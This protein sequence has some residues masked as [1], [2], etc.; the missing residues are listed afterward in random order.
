MPDYVQRLVARND[1]FTEVITPMTT[2]QV[3]LK[4]LP[5]TLQGETP[6]AV[7]HSGGTDDVDDKTLKTGPGGVQET[8]FELRV[9]LLALYADQPAVEG[10]PVTYYEEEAAN[11]LDMLS[12]ELL[13]LVRTKRKVKTKWQ[14]LEWFGMSIASDLLKIDGTLYL[15][16]IVLLRMTLF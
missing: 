15:H 2:P 11:Q 3:K 4:Y 1:L 7:L 5:N 8:V 9:S 16:E 10:G 14:K 12:D 6:C 13:S